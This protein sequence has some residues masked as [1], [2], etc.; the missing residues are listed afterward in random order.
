[1]KIGSFKFFPLSLRPC[2][3]TIIYSETHTHS[4]VVMI[5]YRQL[6]LFF[7]KI[8][9]DWHWEENR[10]TILVMASELKELVV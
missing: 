5:K 2:L 10:N 6:C 3:I 7:L 4:G 9:P 8:L 1:M